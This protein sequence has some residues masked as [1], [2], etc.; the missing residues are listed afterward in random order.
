MIV[1]D[2]RIA[3]VVATGIL[4]V[5]LFGWFTLPARGA[6]FDGV[7]VINPAISTSST[8]RSSAPSASAPIFATIVRDGTA[9][10]YGTTATTV[11]EFLTERDIRIVRGDIVAPDTNER[12]TDGMRVTVR[13][14]VPVSLTVGSQTRTVRTVPTTVSQLLAS[15]HVRLG[16]HDEVSPSLPTLVDGNDRVRVVRVAM[17]TAHVRENIVARVHTRDDASLPAG[18]VVAVAKGRAG[19]RETTFR[20]VRR[21]DAVPTRI[22]LASRIVR[23][24]QTRIVV[25]GIATYTSLARV[26]R[27]GFKNAVRFA[28]TAINM[29]AT[30]YTAACYKC[31]GITASGVRAG[32]GII[33]VDPRVIPLGTKLFVPGYGRAVAG[34]TG[35]AIV[36][37]RVDLGMDT[38][39]D[40]IRYGRRPV[41]V[42]VL[43]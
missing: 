24:P 42:Y 16:V 3:S 4:S 33:A 40:A 9:Y 7:T 43:R 22:T 30:A 17:W 38:Q 15:Q 29:I 20:Y 32:F 2:Q 11:G 10:T 26:A 23:A 14:A 13:F 6:Q 41:T 25:R 8:D 12:L 28:G 34:D 1:R 19:I 37:N 5:G 21:D 35:G 39:H 36:G 31:S 18:H 27:L